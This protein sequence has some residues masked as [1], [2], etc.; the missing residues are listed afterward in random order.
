MSDFDLESF[1]GFRGFLVATSGYAKSTGYR[2]RMVD[3]EA[4]GE[5]ADVVASF[6]ER[7]KRLD[8][9]LEFDIARASKI[10]EQEGIRNVMI[11][12][13]KELNLWPPASADRLDSMAFTDTSEPLDTI[14]WALYNH[15]KSL[16]GDLRETHDRQCH[17]ASFIV[18]FV[19][20]CGQ[21]I[22]TSKAGTKLLL[23]FLERAKEWTCNDTWQ[24][25]SLRQVVISRLNE[26]ADERFVQ[27][28]E[29]WLDRHWEAVA[30]G[31][32]AL[33]AGFALAAL[34]FGAKTRK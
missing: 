7:V 6:A 28:V 21:P 8:P 25:K 26:F 4:G 15:E 17:T 20:A 14:A 32:I 12:T 27:D 2:F 1:P 13:C 33:V 22:E 16:Q 31:G 10:A 5:A 19:H 24:R 30:V 3:L 29:T 9:E 18:D 23:E 34:A 11:S